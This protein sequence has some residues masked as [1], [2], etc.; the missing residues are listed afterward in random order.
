VAEIEKEDYENDL[1]PY[2]NAEDVLETIGQRRRI[3]QL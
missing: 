3:R 1:L 2:S